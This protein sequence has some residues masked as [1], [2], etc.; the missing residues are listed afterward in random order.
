M[1]DVLAFAIKE[2][3]IVIMADAL[4]MTNQERSKAISGHLTISMRLIPVDP[5]A[6]HLVKM[7]INLTS[8]GSPAYPIST[9]EQEHIEPCYR[10]SLGLS[11]SQDYQRPTSC[12]QVTAGSQASV[13][14]ANDNHVVET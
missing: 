13:T 14:C 2:C 10:G 12:T 9:F 6:A 4:L 8:E 3:R 1:V 5:G 7:A 11:F